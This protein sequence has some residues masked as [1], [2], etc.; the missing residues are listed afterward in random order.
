MSET[1]FTPQTIPPTPQNADQAHQIFYVNQ[2]YGMNTLAP[3]FALADGEFSFLENLLPIA[4]TNQNLVAAEQTLSSLL[5]VV[6]G[7][8]PNLPALPSAQ[9]IDR[10]WH[11]AVG[12]GGGQS[13]TNWLI[14]HT[15]QGNLYA[16]NLDTAP[17]LAPV[18]LNGSVIFA[19]PDMTVWQGTQLLVV[20]R[21][22]GYYSFAL[23]GNSNALTWSAGISQTPP[24]SNL[25]LIAVAFG[26][27]WVLAN[28]QTIIASAPNSYTDFNT[29]DGALDV[30]ITD[31]YLRKAVTHLQL[32]GDYLYAV[33]DGAI[34][35][36][37]NVQANG[38]LQVSQ[39]ET[40]HGTSFYS[41]VESIDQQLVFASSDN[42][43]TIQ[44]FY[45]SVLMPSMAPFW[46]SQI[47]L[48]TQPLVLTIAT[49]LGVQVSLVLAK[50]K[51][52][53][54]GPRSVF[55]ALCKGNS[56]LLSQGRTITYTCTVE[57]T[58]P[59]DG[60]AL[61]VTYG[62]DGTNI[63]TC[64]NDDSDTIDLIDASIPFKA[65][66]KLYDMGQP[67]VIKH[68]VQAGADAYGVSPF[69]TFSMQVDTESVSSQA[70]PQFLLQQ[71]AW[72]NASG[73]VFTFTNA[74]QQAI[75]WTVA[76]IVMPQFIAGVAGRYV[77]FTVS[78]TT[79]GFKLAA[80]AV[81]FQQGAP[82]LGGGIS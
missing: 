54:G 38:A 37:Y 62:T 9:I 16:Y 6:P 46:S 58:D 56:L 55:L 27:V 48:L 63:F 1:L 51:D 11:L 73:K 14:V 81:A 60:R 34:Y 52:P 72:T 47:D 23:T 26:R 15:Q 68:Y 32:N 71:I 77:G 31:S 44:G 4:S 39:V 76:G 29:V 13:A 24:A 3:R 69:G 7:P 57:L 66:T 82:W 28:T 43:Y 53:S 67:V 42:L 59:D 35:A 75:Q 30:V 25:S 50:Y 74:Q 10:M 80:L 79:P 5:T 41:A 78:G 36:L 65:V 22:A 70:Q 20:D 21:Q 64:F 12:S 49:I 45:P 19:N 8:G 18:Q 33:G 2:F 61:F 17:V 40:T